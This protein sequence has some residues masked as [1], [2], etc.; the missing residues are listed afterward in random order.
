MFD[1]GVS[2]RSMEPHKQFLFFVIIYGEDMAME[3]YQ[4]ICPCSL[5]LS[6]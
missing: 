1:Y 5:E 3:P 2:K 4:V 6:I